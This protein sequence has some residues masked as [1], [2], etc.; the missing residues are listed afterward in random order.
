MLGSPL[1]VG[2]RVEERSR[3]KGAALEHLKVVGEA[4]RLEGRDAQ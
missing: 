4:K 3:G 1:E 2:V